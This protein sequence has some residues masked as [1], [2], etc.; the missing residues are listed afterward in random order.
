M[1]PF[2]LFVVSFQLVGYGEIVVPSVGARL[3]LRERP[4]CGGLEIPRFR[5]RRFERQ[6]EVGQAAGPL[7]VLLADQPADLVQDSLF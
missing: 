3:E 1:A 5:V 6:E 2:V 4:Q 7:E